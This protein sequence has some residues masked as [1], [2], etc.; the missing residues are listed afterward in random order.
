MGT[1]SSQR[2]GSL[3]ATSIGQLTPKSGDHPSLDSIPSP[4]FVMTSL[5]DGRQTGLAVDLVQLASL[6]PPTIFVSLPKGHSISPMVR[7]SRVFGLCQLREDDRLLLKR[8]SNADD[9]TDNNPFDGLDTTTM[10]TGVPLLTEAL[11]VL[12]CEV[13]MHLDIEADY[14]VYMARVVASKLMDADA[15]PFLRV[16]SES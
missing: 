9:E 11:T 4:I 6:E 14:E 1:R 16:R 13:S 5:H 8:F 7:D 3:T 12:D 2:R 15:T 10:S